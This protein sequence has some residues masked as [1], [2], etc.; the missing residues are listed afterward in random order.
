LLGKT[1]SINREYRETDSMAFRSMDFHSMA[2]QCRRRR[3]ALSPDNLFGT[4]AETG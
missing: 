2:F 4:S 1:G 3:V